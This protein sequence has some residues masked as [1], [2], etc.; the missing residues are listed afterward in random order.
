MLTTVEIDRFRALN[1][2]GCIDFICDS[3]GYNQYFDMLSA[4]I[5]YWQSSSFATFVLLQLFSDFEAK[6]ET[7]T[8]IPAMDL[9]GA[10]EERHGDGND[11]NGDGG[12]ER[13]ENEQDSDDEQDRANKDTSTLGKIFFALSPSTII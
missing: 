3:G 6:K 7:P 1:P 11:N 10:E 9:Q 8:I 12:D 4:H 5:S 13:D 2:H